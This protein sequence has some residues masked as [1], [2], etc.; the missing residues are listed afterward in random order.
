M[1]TTMIPV[2]LGKPA[3][4]A[5]LA[6]MASA[7]STHPYKNDSPVNMTITTDVRRGSADLHIYDI[8]NTCKTSYLGTVGLTDPKVRIA[9]PTSKPSYLVVN[10]SS[11]SLFWGSSST[12]Y[13][14]F[15]TPRAGYRYEA[16]VNYIDKMY[17]ATIYEQEANGG[18]RRKLPRVEPAC[19]SAKAR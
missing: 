13:D 11:T 19:I 15:V 17:G 3:L 5:L 12:S 6:V 14:I 18:A 10:F 4:V 2:S 16:L 7:C 1:K 9:L 8:D